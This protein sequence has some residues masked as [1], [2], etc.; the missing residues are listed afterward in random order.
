MVTY[1]AMD[2]DLVTDWSQRRTTV[3]FTVVLYFSKGF[4]VFYG[5]SLTFRVPPSKNSY[6]TPHRAVAVAV[7]SMYVY[8]ANRDSWQGVHFVFVLDQ[9]HDTG[10]PKR[11][12]GYISNNN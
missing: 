8:S 5:P 12:V 1:K 3:K 11:Q 4:I 2:T 7:T 10:Q 9:M 6:R